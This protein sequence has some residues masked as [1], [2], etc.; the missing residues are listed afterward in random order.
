MLQHRP[1][2]TNPPKKEVLPYMATWTGHE[3]GGTW[4]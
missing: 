4:V 3:F 2:T 1:A